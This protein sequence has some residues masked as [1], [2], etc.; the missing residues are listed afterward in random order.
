MKEYKYY[1]KRYLF[2]KYS[3]R[4]VYTENVAYSCFSKKI[5][6]KKKKVNKY[7]KKTV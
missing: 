1:G 3:G 4:S 7:V 6:T 5:K 2:T